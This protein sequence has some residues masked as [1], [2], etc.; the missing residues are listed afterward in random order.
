MALP[1]RILLTGASGFVGRHLLAHLRARFP[2]SVLLAASREGNI[3][4][5]DAILPLD[6]R[7]PD[8]MA[9][10]LRAAAPD[11]VVHLA[12]QTAV[13]ESFADPTLT[14]RVNV[15]GTLA[16]AHT[17]HAHLPQTLLVHISSAE[18]YGLSF[19][20]GVAL[21][22]DA[23]MSPANPYAAS[24]AAADMALGE[25]SLRG[26]RLVRL[27]PFNHIGP[28]QTPSFALPSFARQI[29]RIEANLQEPILHV[30]ALDRWRDFL[31]VRDVCAAYIAALERAQDLPNGIALNIASGTERRIG[32]VLDAL[33]DR[34][35]V[36]IHV[37]QTPALLRPTDIEHARGDA[38]LAHRL[39]GWTPRENW[40]ETLDRILEDW[41]A[42]TAQYPTG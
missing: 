41:R 5:A 21:A 17:L 4:G 38:T 18:V 28:G 35:R 9:T 11:A 33:L 31:D 3:P 25:M 19:Q 14:W 30:G 12:A 15:D 7:D 34:A 26:L 39:L 20:C 8:G 10:L 6:L 23:A 16:L 22:E 40:D 37:V 13:P 24:K 2:G 32:D 29:A 42:R 27:R 1:G 36:K